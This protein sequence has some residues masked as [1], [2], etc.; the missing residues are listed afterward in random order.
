MTEKY[1]YGEYYWVSVGKGEEARRLIVVACG[2]M[3]KGGEQ[4][5]QSIAHGTIYKV[6]ECKDI[7]EIKE[8]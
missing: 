1:R 3:V 7:E 8:E 6:S 4:Q 5:F 2:E